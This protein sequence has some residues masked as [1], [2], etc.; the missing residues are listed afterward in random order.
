MW[1]ACIGTDK[2][3]NVKC[4][5]TMS[6]GYSGVQ[7]EALLCAFRSATLPFA[8]THTC[9]SFLASIAC[10][11]AQI[12]LHAKY[13]IGVRKMHMGADG[14]ACARQSSGKQH[15]CMCV[16]CAHDVQDIPLHTSLCLTASSTRLQLTISTV[17]PSLKAGR[18][19]LADA[20]VCA[21]HKRDLSIECVTEIPLRYV[22]SLYVDGHTGII[23][24]TSDRP[25]APTHADPRNTPS[26]RYC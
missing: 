1:R 11:V 16:S 17:A 6:A 25:V 5:T 14:H 9:C 18:S 7:K 24:C 19:R 12:S 21:D 23:L 20:C 22:K 26:R 2:A 4:R 3:K 10:M 15:G 8:L 13:S